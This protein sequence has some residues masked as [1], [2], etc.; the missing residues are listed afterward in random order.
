[1]IG[2]F[3]IQG[4]VAVLATTLAF[5]A[6]AGTATFTTTGSNDNISD[7]AHWGG[8]LPDLTGGTLDATVRLGHNLTLDQDIFVHSLDASTTS[9]NRTI[10]VGKIKLGE[11]GIKF[12]KAG[13]GYVVVYSPVEFSTD[14][15][16][17]CKDSQHYFY[18]QLT[19][20][21]PA[22]PPT[23]TKKGP[24]NLYAGLGSANSPFS[25]TIVVE[26]GGL[27]NLATESFGASGDIILKNAGVM[28]FSSA[29]GHSASKSSR[30]L[31]V[32]ASSTANY[33]L[34]LTDFVRSVGEQKGPI[35]VH[36]NGFGVTVVKS[37]MFTVSGGLTNTVERSGYLK[38]NLAERNTAADSQTTLKIS[39]KPWIA[40]YLTMYP[41][42]CAADT[43]LVLAAP[44]NRFAS[45]GGNDA[46]HR[47]LN[48]SIRCDVDGAL[49]DDA[50]TVNLGENMEFDLNGTVQRIGTLISSFA[51]GTPV[52]KNS[53]ANLAT[54]HVTQAAGAGAQTVVIQGPIT[55]YKH[56][57]GDLE[58][59]QENVA[60]GDIVVTQGGISFT[61]AASWRGCGILT[62]GPDASCTVASGS[63]FADTLQVRLDQSATFA[64]ADGCCATQKVGALSID[65]TWMP[66]GLYSA[67]ALPDVTQDAT[68][69]SGDGVLEVTHSSVLDTD[70]YT[71]VIDS[72]AVIDA[73]SLV[74][75]FTNVEI[76]ATGRL[77]LRYLHYFAD[78]GIAFTVAE[79]GVLVLPEGISFLASSFN[80]A[81]ASLVGSLTGGDNPSPGAY[82][83]VQ[84]ISGTGYIYV[85]G[86]PI[87]GTEV[88]WKGEGSDDLMTTPGNWQGDERPDLTN[89]TTIASFAT[90]G[91]QALVPGAQYLNGMRFTTSVAFEINSA[92]SSPSDLLR[93]GAGGVTVDSSAGTGVFY[94][95]VP[96]Y[97]ENSQTWSVPD[98]RKFAIDKKLMSD[99]NSHHTLTI[100]GCGGAGYAYLNGADGEFYGD[101]IV[102]NQAL[103]WLGGRNPTGSNGVI[104]VD[105]SGGI[106]VQTAFGRPCEVFKPIE[107]VSVP[108]NPYVPIATSVRNGDAFIRA[109]VTYKDTG[110]TKMFIV[111]EGAHLH[112]AGGVSGN[113]GIRLAL[114]GANASAGRRSELIITN[115]P[116]ISSNQ[117]RASEGTVTSDGDYGDVV[118]A[119]Q[120]NSFL[121]LGGQ[122]FNSQSMTFW[123]TANIRCKV[124]WAFDKSDMPLYI[125]NNSYLDM[126][127][128]SQRIGGLYLRHSGGRVVYITNSVARAATL[129]INQTEEA[130]W[131][132]MGTVS[133]NINLVMD[134]T[135]AMGVTNDWT[136][137]GNVTLRGGGIDFS[138][139][140]SWRGAT[141]IVVS[142]ASTHLS[143]AAA[144]T[145]YKK[146]ALSLDGGALVTIAAGV[147]QRVGSLFVNGV[148]RGNGR[149]TAASAPDVVSGDGEL[150][151]RG[152]GGT[153]LILR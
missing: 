84:G 146:A 118:F 63:T 40:P 97:L 15:E 29:S 117:I 111:G 54:L 32:D 23:L 113:T 127:G 126:E 82:V 96:L 125:G 9:G 114:T 17:Y 130:N 71:L 120:S 122:N 25:G 28:C 52:I 11:G 6:A 98:G 152:Q 142:G 38:L 138:D 76:T 14:C 78:R 149:Y 46:G 42:S 58:L 135:K 88:V 115:K 48:V 73:D 79:G 37:G 107:V 140:G 86:V 21:D 85:A 124:D 55:L 150:W 5:A 12:S 101:I 99:P 116:W 24:T 50:L 119:V 45:I 10:N 102:K 144:N 1:M 44:G 2:M 68:H 80:Y 109:P 26:Q 147:T 103:L 19:A 61:S 65:G 87:V 143:I 36:T 148:E 112:L 132:Q 81:G 8:T 151:V 30:P 94:V 3:H 90:A 74:G 134:G 7:A 35:T 106:R 59:T 67:A 51:Q 105:T 72:S 64:F 18:G 128:T 60:E 70:G 56:G 133:G 91:A 153:T 16:I 31:V 77:E 33:P 57:A 49:D 104:R 4:R 20:T 39:G 69:F 22:N 53:A 34:G 121:R 137:V 43:L 75:N 27:M 123:N 129:Y 66:A 93:L 62:L 41:V 47:W 141:N 89:G 139:T 13:G 131:K 95:H 108:G 110:E 92:Y 145:L 100:D 83:P 136:A